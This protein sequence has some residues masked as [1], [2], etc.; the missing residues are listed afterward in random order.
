M[1]LEELSPLSLIDCELP[2]FSGG[3]TVWSAP[4]FRGPLPLAFTP[5]DAGGSGRLQ[6]AGTLVAQ[7]EMYG[8][9]GIGSNAGGVRCGNYAGVQIK[10]IGPSLLGGPG[11]DKWHRHGALSLQDAVRDTL[12]GELFSVA[13]PNGAVRALAI[14]DLGFTFA[15][16]FGKEKTPSTAPR[17][18]LYREQ[19]LRVAHFM[20]SSFMNVG[21]ELAQRELARMRDGIPRLVNWL[22]AAEDRIDFEAAAR[23][24]QKMFDS[25]MNQLAVLRTKRLVHGSLIPSNL[26]IDGRFVD[27]TTTTAVSTLQPVLVSV[28]GW[29]SQHQHHQVLL[30]VPDLLFY[31]AKFDHR[32]AVPR[33]RLQAACEEVA[34]ELAAAHH[35]YL[36]REHLGLVG[37]PLERAFQLDAQNIEALL[38]ALV[39]VI[40]SGSVQGHMYF[41][42]D[43]HE[44]LPQAGAD[45]ILAVIAQAI[46][47]TTGLSLA[48]G[49]TYRP[50]PGAFPPGVRDGFI[51]AFAQ[52][53]QCMHADGLSLVEQGMAWL[54]RATQRNADLK[55]L[56]RRWLD[57]VINDV[58]RNRAAEV[59]D[60]IEEMLGQW[61]GVFHTPPDGRVTLK[62]W[63]T[64][65]AVS[66]TPEGRLEA[67]GAQFSPLALAAFKPAMDIR[68]RHQWLFGVSTLNQSREFGHA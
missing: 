30:A 11:L 38:S 59:S 26:C 23:G 68:P 17:A 49:L 15:T 21:H 46:C 35:R 45:D 28:G 47:E 44:M 60:F 4:N 3:K 18:L 61:T 33:A 1:N 57:G 16:E 62:G 42:G 56:Y 34:A 54:I 67:E 48:R 51:R 40:E 22:C 24:V 10:G 65:S 41:G 8:G 43:D 58:C 63:L 66:L 5:V 20:R 9:S 39:A 29:S 55:P 32:C 50:D 6:R 31:I 64:E 27:F 12:I 7:L 52:A 2:I 14:A 13:A 19:S 36:M 53:A 25:L 37:F